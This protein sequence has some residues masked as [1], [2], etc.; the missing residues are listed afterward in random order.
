M[1]GNHAASRTGVCIVRAETDASARLLIT[2]TARRDVENAARESVLRTAS[3][4]AALACVAD[5]LAAVG[6]T[7]TGTGG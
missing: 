5:F 4:E 2:I 7:D 6:D 1:V 3:V